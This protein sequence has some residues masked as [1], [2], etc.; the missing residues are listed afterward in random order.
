M[1]VYY[2]PSIPCSCSFRQNPSDCLRA[3]KEGVKI[4]TPES[5]SSND[6]RFNLAALNVRTLRGLSN[7]SAASRR[8]SKRSP[9]GFAGC[10]VCG[11]G[12]SFSN[13]TFLRCNRSLVNSPCNWG[14]VVE[15]NRI[16]K[17]S[18][19]IL[20]DV[21]ACHLG[22]TSHFYPLP[23]A[24]ECGEA[25]RRQKEHACSIVTKYSCRATHQVT[26]SKLST[27]MSAPVARAIRRDIRRSSP[28]IQL[29]FRNC[30]S[31]WVLASGVSVSW[32]ICFL[33]IECN[34]LRKNLRSDR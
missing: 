9:I 15:R 26:K 12:L 34:P 21:Y 18:L 23:T 32:N 30:S 22:I 2:S 3:F 1:S 4:R 20:G 25:S 13:S 8:V 19:I 10:F 27:R 29:A 14:R 31:N 6:S 11:M 5:P 17:C 24:V 28:C 16:I 7:M 33:P